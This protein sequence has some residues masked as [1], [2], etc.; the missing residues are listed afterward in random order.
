MG[1]KDKRDLKGK[2]GYWEER[3]MGRR[4]NGKGGKCVREV[5]GVESHR[6]VF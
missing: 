6:N 5:R 4:L 3:K 1:S 2:K